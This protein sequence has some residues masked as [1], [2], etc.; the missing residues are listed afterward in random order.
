MF[1]VC[2]KPLHLFFSI[3]DNEIEEYI[4]LVSDVLVGSIEFFHD[5]YEFLSKSCVYEFDPISDFFN[6]SFEYLY[7]VLGVDFTCSFFSYFQENFSLYFNYIP[8]VDKSLFGKESVFRLP[9][10]SILAG[11]RIINKVLSQHNLSFLNSLDILTWDDLS[12]VTE[13]S[14]VDKFGFLTREFFDAVA[15]I[16]DVCEELLEPRAQWFFSDSLVPENWEDLG[17]VLREWLASSVTGRN[18]ERDLDVLMSRFG[19]DTGIPGTLEDLAVKYEVGTRERVRQIEKKWVERLLEANSGRKLGPIW[20]FLYSYVSER[21]V[22]TP[23]EFYSACKK[24][25][26]WPLDFSYK[27]V[28]RILQF[29]PADYVDD[30]VF[31]D[32]YVICSEFYKCLRCEK[33]TEFVRNCFYDFDVLNCDELS[34]YSAA[35]CSS[36]C[37]LSACDFF[38]PCFFEYFCKVNFSESREVIYGA[39]DQSIYSRPYYD[40]RHGS[41]VS[42]FEYLMLKAKKPLHFTEFKKLFSSFCPGRDISDRSVH[43]TLDRTPNVVLWGRGTFFHSKW[44]PFDYDVLRKI[45]DLVFLRLKSGVPVVSSY[46]PFT[47]FE[48]TLKEAGVP[49]EIALYSLLRMLGDPRLSCPHQPYIV[50]KEN[51]NNFSSLTV[52]LEDF[53]KDHGTFVPADTIKAYAFDELNLKEFQL[54]NFVAEIEDIYGSISTG[55]I[56]ESNLNLEKDFL[57]SLVAYSKKKAAELGNISLR[58]IYDDQIVICRMMG[59][60][61]LSILSAVLNKY[62]YGSVTVDKYYKVHSSSSSAANVTDHILDY[63]RNKNSPCTYSELYDQFVVERGYGK[64]SVNFVFYGSGVY[65]YATGCVACAET[66][67]LDDDLLSAV[68]EEVSIEYSERISAGEVYGSVYDVVEKR[69]LPRLRPG[70]YWS[71]ALLADVINRSNT[72]K[73]LGYNK[74]PYIK[75]SDQIKSYDQLIAAILRFKFKGSAGLSTFTDCLSSLKVIDRSIPSSILN[76]SSELFVDN[77]VISVRDIYAT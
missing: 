32:E 10:S 14:L 57:D 60:S 56:H 62:S 27:A 6:F 54:N 71:E 17:G 26:G 74:I 16:G 11:S 44:A 72:Y 47:E 49:N 3:S 7:S 30:F 23:T 76:D 55:Y 69:N 48:A 12:E 4:S 33:L 70:Y 36:N 18:V 8:K 52:F 20:V 28:W 65:R 68:M 66:L 24:K 67:G 21:K 51:E 35:E 38:S 73:T 42:A 75:I 59:I 5:E 61:S 40:A 43:A 77:G 41:L 45:E 39:D 25:F 1:N 22:V 2:E 53:I 13:S 50:L 46:G 34:R 63:I 29:C 37:G 9:E 15:R 64:A 58:K 31:E 19:W